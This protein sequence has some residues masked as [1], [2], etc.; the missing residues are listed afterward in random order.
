MPHPTNRQNTRPIDRMGLKGLHAVL[1]YLSEEARNAETEDDLRAVMGIAQ[2]LFLPSRIYAPIRGLESIRAE[3]IP[4]F[5]P[6]SQQDHSASISCLVRLKV[7]AILAPLFDDLSR[8]MNRLQHEDP[9]T[10]ANATNALRWLAT[11]N[12]QNC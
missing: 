10:F 1:E 8:R 7:P 11:G 4:P 12:I 3:F 9:E 6:E 5:A 2:E